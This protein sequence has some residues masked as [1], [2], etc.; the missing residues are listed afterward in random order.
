MRDRFQKSWGENMK[1]ATIGLATCLCLVVSADSGASGQ[2]TADLMLRQARHA[3][4]KGDIESLQALIRTAR[5]EAAR[6]N[7]FEANL[8]I[9]VLDA[10][11]V[12]AAHDHQNDKVVKQ[13]AQDGVAAA[14]RAVKLN[15]ESSEAHRLVGELLGELIPHVFAGGMRYG[16]HSTGEIEKAMQLDSHNP[17]AY[18]ARG[19][20]Y[21]FTPKTFGGDI[22]KAVDTWKQA[23]AIAPTSDAAETAH[24][25]LARAYQSLGKSENARTE[26]DEALKMNPERLFAK[27]VQAQPA[28]K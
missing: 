18:V 2:E 1:T 6:T 24:I 5:D 19:N 20:A 4:D 13:A 22:E 7:S 10:C 8:G 17:N 9:A 14:E 21:F 27:L 26:I 23:I 15:T 16:S 25:R 11:L 28:T 12:E 3:R